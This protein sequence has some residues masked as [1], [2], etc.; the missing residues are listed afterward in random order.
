[1]TVHI[2]PYAFADIPLF[3]VIIGS[4]L[5]GLVLAYIMHLIQT[6]VIGFSMRKKDAKIKQA[7]N[8]IAELTKQV[9]KLEIENEKLKNTSAGNEPDD[10]NAL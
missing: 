3:Y 6:M 4:L 8:E 9:H 10:P 5:A 7:K 2:G 1:M